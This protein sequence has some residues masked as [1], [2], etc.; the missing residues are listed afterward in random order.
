MRS[1]AV[2]PFRTLSIHPPHFRP[3]RFQRL[4]FRSLCV[5]GS[6]AACA[7]THPN[8]GASSSAPVSK[9]PQPPPQASA[10][11]ASASPATPTPELHVTARYTGFNRPGEVVPAPETFVFRQAVPATDR[12][13]WCHGGRT[14]RAEARTATTTPAL[15]LCVHGD[16]GVH[17]H[18]SLPVEG[19]SPI[20]GS[21]HAAIPPTMV[22]R[23]GA[24]VAIAGHLDV[25]HQ[26]TPASFSGL[27]PD[28]ELTFDGAV[29]MSPPP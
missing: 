6:L 16:G 17:A 2:N 4:G 20:A 10:S 21:R 18:V 3:L 8:R 1:R 11:Q 28:A 24:V 29:A 13:G 7:P 19:G 27:A 15:M 26:G 12:T 23:N 22:K 14:Y 9:P 25:P 5:A